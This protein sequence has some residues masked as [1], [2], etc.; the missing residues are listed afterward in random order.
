ELRDE[1]A[2]RVAFADAHFTQDEVRGSLTDRGMVFILLGPPTYSGSRPLLTGEDGAAD[3]S[4]LSRYGRAEVTGAGKGGPSHS[5]RVAR[6]DKVT[7]PGTSIQSAASNWIE[8]WHYYRR[9]LLREIPYQELILEFVT[10]VGYG[11]G[12][13][14]RDS[15]ALTSLDRARVAVRH[16]ATSA[17]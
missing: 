3:S 13:L 7:G 8:I 16:G 5:A 1:F 17:S 12:V 15:K 14:Q 6:V 4:A 2:R 11:K 10:K 9:D